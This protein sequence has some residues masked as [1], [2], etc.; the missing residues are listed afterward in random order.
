MSAHVADSG[1]WA[2]AST[3]R[4]ADGVRRGK[5]AMNLTK[6]NSRDATVCETYITK[7]FKTFKGVTYSKSSRRRKCGEYYIAA[8]GGP[9]GQGIIIRVYPAI[10]GGEMFD[11][12]V[13]EARAAAALAKKPEKIMMESGAF[14][15]RK[16]KHAAGLARLRD[17]LIRERDG[18]EAWQGGPAYFASLKTRMAKI[19]TTVCDSTQFVREFSAECSAKIRSSSTLTREEA[20][21]DFDLMIGFSESA[22]IGFEARTTNWGDISGKLEQSFKAGLWASGSAK[23][24]M[25]ALGISAEVQAAIAVGML[26]NVEGD[27]KW[28]KGN[29]GLQLGG[30]AEAFAGARA[31]LAAKLSLTAREGFEASIAAGAFA[32]LEFKA[33]G[34]CALTY[35]GEKL[36]SAGGS[37]SI[38]FGAGA[39]FEASIKAP[40]FGPTSISMEGNLT[41]GMGGA[42]AVKVEVDFDQMALASSSAFREVVYWR[43]M[44]RGYEATLM[45]SDAKNLYYLN[46]CI[47]RLGQEIDEENA[48]IASYESTPMEKRGLLQEV[49]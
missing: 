22:A 16:Q 36:A 26:L 28:T 19:D 39:S 5:A 33:E 17:E 10:F 42:S 31:E 23:A 34:S 37:A 30:K 3:Q 27:L 6:L 47:K 46:K 18:S 48:S 11:D 14:F 29:A 44:A 1:E 45:E 4:L 24:K 2:G 43:V 8:A 49:G 25:S 38:T 32:G 13:A 20:A 9:Y 7:K 35:K 15:D 12:D 21:A 41:L 40:L